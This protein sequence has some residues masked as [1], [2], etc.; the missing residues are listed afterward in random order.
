MTATRRRPSSDSAHTSRSSTNASLATDEGSLGLPFDHRR[1]RDGRRAVGDV[2]VGRG[3]RRTWSD[4]RAAAPRCGDDRRRQPVLVAE[5]RALEPHQVGRQVEAELVEQHTAGAVDGTQRVGLPAVAIQRDRQLR[6]QPFA[7]RVLLHG[8]LELGHH[9]RVP[10][11]VE[12]HV[13]AQ[14]VG[15]QAQLV[16]AGG[17]GDRP[18]HLVELGQVGERRA[19]PQAERL[20]EVGDGR[21]RVG[22]HH[23][24]GARHLVLERAACPSRAR[25]RSST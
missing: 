13:E 6:R 21:V 15:T 17:R 3:R 10:A 1:Q 18:L 19:T 7:Q 14:L 5:D 24:A 22:A 4:A 23:L 20:V 9:L 11:E 12:H 2:R 25:P 8:R 16:E